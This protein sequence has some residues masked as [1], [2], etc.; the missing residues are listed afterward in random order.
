MS[1]MISKKIDQIFSSELN[2]NRNLILT[3]PKASNTLIKN[4]NKNNIKDDYNIIGIFNKRRNEQDNNNKGNIKFINKNQEI[5]RIHSNKQVK[6]ILKKLPD[7]VIKDYLED[8][9][10]PIAGESKKIKKAKFFIESKVEEKDNNY[11]LRRIQSRKSL[12]K[13][14]MIE[15]QKYPKKETIFDRIN[16]RINESKNELIIKLG[17]QINK[18]EFSQRFYNCKTKKNNF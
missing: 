6:S 2:K 5:N 18:E 8:E 12:K 17:E 16:R 10:S 15:K 3:K 13:L 9:D 7:T 4:K 14:V 1:Q 11:K